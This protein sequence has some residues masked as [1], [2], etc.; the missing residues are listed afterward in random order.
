[1]LM[2]Y[3][4]PAHDSQNVSMIALDIDGTLVPRHD[5]L[6]VVPSR[7]SG[8][9]LTDQISPR[10][11]AAVMAA[12]ATGIHV[13][14]ASG[15]SAPGIIQTAQQ[16]GLDGAWAAC[17]NGAVVVHL[18]PDTPPGFVVHSMS[19]FDPEP[20][21]LAIRSSIPDAILAVEDPGHGFLVSRAFPEGELEGQHKEVSFDRLCAQPV[22]RIV[23][24]HLD[25][26]SSDMSQA[27]QNAGLATVNYEIGWTGWMDIMAS[28]VDKA[29][30]LEHIRQHLG[31]ARTQT[32]VVG[33]GLNDTDMLAWASRAVAMGGAV[34]E[35]VASATEVTESAFNDGVALV[36]EDVLEKLGT[37]KNAMEDSVKANGV[38]AY[39]L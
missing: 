23:V 37:S 34:P 27:A 5:S 3:R 39:R 32:V 38:R 18:H 13:V 24:R 31:V 33:D 16:L 30:G 7:N 19:T 12:V 21:L 28:G 9:V 35:V 6:E 17:S 1:M 11:I 36:I 26:S 2:T 22:T 20:I 29:S 8:I 14:L 4:R 25:M 15:R 10:V